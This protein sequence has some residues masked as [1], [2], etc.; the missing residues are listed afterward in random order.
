MDF[1]PNNRRPPPDLLRIQVDSFHSCHTLP[2]GCDVAALQYQVENLYE[3]LL[4]PQTE[5]NCMQE[6]FDRVRAILKT[7]FPGVGVHLYGKN[8]D[9]YI[10]QITGMGRLTLYRNWTGTENG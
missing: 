2:G 10:A 5:L 4:P 7:E 8:K 1:F 6:S 9:C 3:Q